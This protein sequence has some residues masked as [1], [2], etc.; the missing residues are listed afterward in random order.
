[1]TYVH[2]RNNLSVD[3]MPRHI[4]NVRRV[5]EPSEDEESSDEREEVKEN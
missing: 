5:L 2:S 4:L 3:G 1:M